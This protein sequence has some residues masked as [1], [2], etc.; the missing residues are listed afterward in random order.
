M[1]VKCTWAHICRYYQKKG[2][3]KINWVQKNKLPPG[4]L[5]FTRKCTK[6]PMKTALN[7]CFCAEMSV[8][9]EIEVQKR[10]LTGSVSAFFRFTVQNTIPP[11]S[12]NYSWESSP[13]RL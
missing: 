5:N 3:K 1:T 11:G 13:K 12:L 6:T 10:S 9:S 7:M 4:S 2:Q 8:L